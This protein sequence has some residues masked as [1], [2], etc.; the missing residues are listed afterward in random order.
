MRKILTTWVWSFNFSITALLTKGPKHQICENHFL[1]L[2]CFPDFETQIGQQHFFVIWQ[3]GQTP[4]QFFFTNVSPNGPTGKSF[5]SFFLL[6]LGHWPTLTNPWDQKCEP[7]PKMTNRTF[8]CECLAHQS[9][10]TC[11]AAVPWKNRSRKK[12]LSKLHLK[13]KSH[14]IPFY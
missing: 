7:G 6:F 13:P 14:C 8:D 3:A 5:F 12:F 10:I 2:N 9:T 11:F 1:G 4:N